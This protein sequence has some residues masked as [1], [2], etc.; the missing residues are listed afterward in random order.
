MYTSFILIERASTYLQILSLG[1]QVLLM[2]VWQ[3]ISRY[4]SEIEDKRLNR[5]QPIVDYLVKENILTEANMCIV[6]MS[7]FQQKVMNRQPRPEEIG[8]HKNE[9]C[10]CF[11]LIPS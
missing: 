11:L 3:N 9:T 10:K 1:Q 6:L 2:T 5:L 8:H 7:I 4:N